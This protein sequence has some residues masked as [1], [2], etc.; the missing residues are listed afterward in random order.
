[1]TEIKKA[2]MI[3]K[4]EYED[5]NKEMPTL[6]EVLQLC[7]EPIW[8][9]DDDHRIINNKGFSLLDEFMY[10]CVIDK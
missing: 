3:T 6:E 2:F 8:D 5:T 9:Q 7:K 1:M 10:V 4:Q